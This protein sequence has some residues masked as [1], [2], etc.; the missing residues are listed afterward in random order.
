MTPFIITGTQRT[1]SATISR[2]LGYHNSVACGWEW[3]HQVSWL[4]RVE[5]CRRGLHG[6]FRL[7]C[8]RHREQIA[9]TISE[10]TLWLGYKS[11]FRAN[12]KWVVK[13]SIA[14][15]L[16]LD[17]FRETLNWW[18]REPTIH[19]VHMVRTDNLAWLRSKFVARRVGSF[20]AGQS[21]PEDVMV[22]VPIRSSLKRLR[23]KRWLDQRLG[24]LRH[25][26]PYHVI[27]YEDLLTD[28]NGV[29]RAVQRFLGLE[30]QLM[31]LEQVRSRQS[32]G[33]P[34]DRHVRNYQE[35]LT[36]LE[37]AALLTAP[38]PSPS[39]NAPT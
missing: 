27:R 34:V 6:D 18:Q 28:L 16:I 35:L 30:P 23:M 2:L 5:A 39:R 7:L 9:A 8:A 10:T 25:T 11:L 20:W 31:P 12:D 26:N 36:A 33:I 17:R 14:A 19:I 15:S 32:E 1:G 4:R 21:Y 3:P 13:P 24:E 38:L 37:R 29:T 22:D